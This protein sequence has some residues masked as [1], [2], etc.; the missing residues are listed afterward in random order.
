MAGKSPTA[1]ATIRGLDNKEIHGQMGIAPSTGGRG[2]IDGGRGD[3]DGEDQP[4][5][6][7]VG[8]AATD[9]TNYSQTL[10]ILIFAGHPRDIQSTRV[11]E[12][13]IVF[14]ENES[15]NLT[16]QLQGQH[17]SFKVKEIWNKPP[18]RSRPR[19]LRR[20]A[21]STLPTSSE[22]DT[23]LRDAILRT[24]VDKV[25][26]DWTCQ[27]WVG[28]VLTELQNADLITVDEGDSALNGMV[29]CISQAPWK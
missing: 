22:F 24:S 18:P 13:C 23:K 12:L 17:P 2:N 4:I 1:F 11:T 27:S 15:T 14:N 8:Q 19:F 6:S 20:F 28:D 16:I 3:G 7:L 29:N 25:E 26:S 9:E 10:W 5:R 21:V